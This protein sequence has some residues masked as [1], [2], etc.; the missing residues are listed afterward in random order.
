MGQTIPTPQGGVE[1]RSD[2]SGT[3]VLASGAISSAYSGGTQT[4]ST[5]CR[6]FSN[7]TWWISCTNKSSAT[8]LDVSIQW[9]EDDS[10]FDEQ[11][12]EAVS[13]GT[14]TVSDYEA[15]FDITGD[16][17]TFV[18]HLS[19]PTY[20]RRYAKFRIKADTGTPTV[21]AKVQRGA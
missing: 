13:S 8:R 6:D 7:A 4:G 21:S 1:V 18:K 17:A 20:G 10:N 2:A 12:S 19:L 16:S 11:G 15:Q 14:A 9:S 3:E 5:D